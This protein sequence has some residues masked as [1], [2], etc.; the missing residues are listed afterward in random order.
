[1][2]MIE[3]CGFANIEQVMLNY[4]GLLIQQKE[5]IKY[6]ELLMLNYCDLL[7][8][9][10]EFI[11]YLVDENYEDILQKYREIIGE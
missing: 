7:I 11:K 2:K 10:R 6:I 8:Q 3:K 5:F 9:Q 4:C 1:M